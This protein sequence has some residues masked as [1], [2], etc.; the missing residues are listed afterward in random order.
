MQKAKKRGKQNSWP[1]IIISTVLM[2]TATSFAFAAPIVVNHTSVEE[3]DDGLIP[4]YW[5]NQVKSRGMIFHLTGQSHGQQLIGD[6]DDGSPDCIGGLEALEDLDSKY[7][8]QVKCDLNDL[9]QS[10]ALH[11]LK[12]QYI[13][14]SWTGGQY[15][16][17]NDDEHY[18]TTPTGR[19]YTQNGIQ[20]AADQGDTI[21]FSAWLWSWHV[22]KGYASNE[23]GSSGSFDDARRDDYFDYIADFNT[24]PVGTRVGYITA[25]TDINNQPDPDYVG[26]KG[27]RVTRYNQDIRAEGIANDGVVFDQGDIENWNYDNTE[28]RSDSWSGHTLRLRHEDYDA[29]DDGCGHGSAALGI[30]KAKALWWLAARL[31]GWPGVSGCCEGLTD[32]VDGDPADVCDEGDMTALIDYLF[33]TFTPPLCMDEANADG[34]P[35]GIIDIGDLT[36]LIDYLFISFAEPAECL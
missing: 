32:N 27:W 1:V 20:Q 36:A 24:N 23:D 31:A 3:F 6:E 15:E 18:W 21:A 7:S 11:I 29:D 34:R 33:I 17:R 19:Q 30:K 5:I 22:I 8:V 16:C 35:D 2:V 12:G 25:I 10:N 26:T 9:N 28:Q 14:S 4:D 13:S